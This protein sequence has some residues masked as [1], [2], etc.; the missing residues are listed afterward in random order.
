[1]NETACSDE[2]RDEQWRELDNATDVILTLCEEADIVC[3]NKGDYEDASNLYDIPIEK[4]S[5][6][7]AHGIM[8]ERVLCRH[9]D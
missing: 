8:K 6:E 9:N 3:V 2:A 5:Q 1:M 7:Q 4:V